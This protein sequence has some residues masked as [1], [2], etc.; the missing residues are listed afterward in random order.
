MVGRNKG[1]VGHLL[2]AGI[3]VPTFHCII[4]Q[5][6]LFAK[7]LGFPDVMQM[8]VKIIN[9]LKGGHNALTHRK[10]VAFLAEIN[11][12][13]GDITLFTEV[14]W[15]SRGKSLDRLFSLRDKILIFLQK[16][17][18]KKDNDIICALS[19]PEFLLDL[20]F[21]I[22]IALQFNSLNLVLQGK[23]KNICELFYAVKEF[24]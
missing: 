15:L 13:F 12:D 7:T 6:A 11:S 10:L 8:A 20:A 18:S 19:S 2:K 14:R 5:H 3:N 23:N 4:H 24:S 21:L 22:D 9:R 1:F 16:I 17:D